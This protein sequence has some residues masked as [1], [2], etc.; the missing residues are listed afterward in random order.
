MRTEPRGRK[1]RLITT[2]QAQPSEKKRWYACGP[3]RM[4]SLKEGAMWHVDPLLGNDHKISNYTTAVTRQ[5]PV[6][7]NRG[8]VL[9]VQSVPM[10]YKQEKLLRSE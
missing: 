1:A 4:N 10:C 8:T 2:L 5:Q 9:S 3:F 7:N 6:N